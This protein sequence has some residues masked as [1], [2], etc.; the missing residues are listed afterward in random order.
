MF[1]PDS[2]SK[3]SSQNDGLT[4]SQQNDIEMLV[5]LINDESDDTQSTGNEQE[6][7]EEIDKTWF[8]SSG[9]CVRKDMHEIEVTF[10]MGF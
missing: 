1:N 8:P 7:N 10:I 9:F 3:V 2:P 5:E 4:E 6:Q